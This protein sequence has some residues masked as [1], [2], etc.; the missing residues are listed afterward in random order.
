MNRQEK[1][2]KARDERLGEIRKNNKGTIMKIIEYKDCMNIIV[3]FQDEYRYRIETRYDSFKNGQVGNPYD[4]TVYNIGYLGVGIYN[5]KDHKLAYGEWK[6]M[7]ERCYDP[8]YIN[9]KMTYKDCFVCDEWLCYQNFAKWFYENYYSIPNKKMRLD[10]DILYKGNKIYSPETCVFVTERINSLFTKAD[11]SRGKFPIGCAIDGNKIRVRCCTLEKREELGRFPLNRPFQ[12]F[13]CYKQF[14][15][16]YIKEVADEYK[17]LIPIELY[18][19][20]YRWEV[21]I[22]D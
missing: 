9:K 7:L 16:K 2:E 3:E 11:K 12:A 20:M 1:L 5:E 14:K 18:E 10:K 13:T 17:D 15:E 4:K 22:N 8:Y 6:G 21:E 19:A